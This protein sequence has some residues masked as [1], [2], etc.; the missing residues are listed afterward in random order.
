MSSQWGPS[1]ESYLE[2]FG[3]KSWSCGKGGER[4]ASLYPDIVLESWWQTLESCSCL[5][6]CTRN[7]EENVALHCRLL[8]TD[9]LSGYASKCFKRSNSETPLICQGCIPQPCGRISKL[10]QS[11]W[12]DRLLEFLDVETDWK[13]HIDSL[14]LRSE[15][16]SS[17]SLCPMKVASLCFIKV[18]Y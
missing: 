16:H 9:K 2:H 6:H 13:I 5:L 18:K 8:W 10:S 15:V 17:V 7:H 14:V 1:E 3:R 4:Y 12:D 11:Q